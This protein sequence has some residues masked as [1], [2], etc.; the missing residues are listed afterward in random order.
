MSRESFNILLGMFELDLSVGPGHAALTKE[1]YL[2]ICLWRLANDSSHCR[3]VGHQ[4]GVANS[5]VCRATMRV[6][7]ALI[8]N[9]A[10]LALMHWPQNDAEF[11]ELAH[12]MHTKSMKRSDAN[13]GL[14][15]RVCV[16][17]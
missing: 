17:S 6:V 3:L 11:Q 8:A 2:A 12:G 1:H 9:P 7:D 13:G 4:M 15:G 14:Q 16:F 5:T 10:F